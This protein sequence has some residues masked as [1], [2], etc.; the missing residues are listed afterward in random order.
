M[1]R[2]TL[3]LAAGG[4]L[5]VALVGT[6]LGANAAERTSGGDDTARPAAVTSTDATVPA[7]PTVSATSDD[8]TGPAVPTDTGTPTESSTPTDPGTPTDGSST[9]PAP[10]PTADRT[11]P[12]SG[13][14]GRDRAV[15]IAREHVGGGKLEK[16]ESEQEHGRQVWSVRLIQDGNRVRVDVDVA[17]GRIT[18]TERKSDH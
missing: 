14:V 12:S 13:K 6:A 11:V 18:R 10:A 7:D 15:E 8:S 9:G 4:V 17:T 1:T 2:K 3:I 5:A 16:V